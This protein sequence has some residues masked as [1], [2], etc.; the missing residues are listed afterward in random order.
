MALNSF[1]NHCSNVLSAALC[2]FFCDENGNLTHNHRFL[3]QTKRK[4]AHTTLEQRFLKEFKATCKISSESELKQQKAIL[5]TVPTFVTAHS[6]C[7]S[8]DTRVSYRWCLL[9]TVIFLRGFKTIRRKQNLHVPNVV[10]IS[11]ENWG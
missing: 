7:A 10:G 1:R 3:L 5:R 9:N 4:A 2:F 11:K 6:F 8:R